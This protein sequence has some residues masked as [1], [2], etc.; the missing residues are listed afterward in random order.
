MTI[1][2]ICEI[3][4]QDGIV[5]DSESVEATRIKGDDEYD[6]VRIKLLAELAGARIPMQIDIG[7]GDAV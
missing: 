2:A 3:Q 7:F 5:F 6:G 1:R 4:D